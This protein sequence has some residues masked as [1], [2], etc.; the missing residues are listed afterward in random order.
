MR[1]SKIVEIAAIFEGRDLVRETDFLYSETDLA[2]AGD[3]MWPRCSV[4]RGQRGYRT[5]ERCAWA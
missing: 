4:C 1:K 3:G 5:G 2:R